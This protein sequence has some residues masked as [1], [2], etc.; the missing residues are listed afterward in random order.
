MQQKS[1]KV[2]LL[3]ANI[4]GNELAGKGVMRLGQNF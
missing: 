3:T 4:L 1:K 2:D